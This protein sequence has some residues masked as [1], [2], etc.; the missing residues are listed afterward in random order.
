[1]D[2]QSIVVSSDDIIITHNRITGT[3]I[4][5]CLHC[6][7]RYRESNINALHAKMLIH[8]ANCN[9]RKV[10]SAMDQNTIDTVYN[11][12]GTARINLLVANALHPSDCAE[13]MDSCEGCRIAL[14]IND[15]D[16]VLDLTA[17]HTT[18][19]RKV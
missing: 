11:L 7:S 5:R 6:E 17:G 16:N 1:M 8:R 3:N 12:T 13:S 2:I 10:K 19:Y 9:A 18:Y 4:G 15:L 14:A